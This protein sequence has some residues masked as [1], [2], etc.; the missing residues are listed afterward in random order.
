MM[1]KTD[2]TPSTLLPGRICSFPGNETPLA[3]WLAA[4]IQTILMLV[5]LAAAIP[6]Y[7]L[8]SVRLE[9]L[10]SR[11]S[12]SCLNWWSWLLSPLHL[13]VVP[14]TG[15]PLFASLGL[16]LDRRVLPDLLAGLPSPLS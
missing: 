1:N 8:A 9:R 2:S 12:P 3:R 15:P 7:V 6:V 4:A 5:L 13:P 16:H 10:G 11:I 14:L